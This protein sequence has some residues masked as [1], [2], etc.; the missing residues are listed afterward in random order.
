MIYS[1]RMQ[2][3]DM[4][5][6]R[7]ARP[8]PQPLAFF[9]IALATLSCYILGYSLT[10]IL[11]LTGIVAAILRARGYIRGG[12]I[13]WANLVFFLNGRRLHVYG[14]ERMSAG[15][16]YLVLANHC[17]M[18]DIP[19]LLAVAPEA[20]LVGRDKLMRIPVFS[21]LLKAIRYIPIDTERM[22]QA[23]QAIDEAVR[24]AGQGLSIGMFPEGTR[25][26]TGS[27]QRLKRGFIYVLRASGLDVLPL[28]IRGTFALKP[29]KQLYMDPREKIEV[30]VHPPIPNGELVALTDE[31][32]MDKVR[33]VLEIHTGGAD[34]RQ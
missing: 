28:T 3:T 9:R 29:K 33:S 12:L 26:P 22:R 31:Q 1:Q 19:V 21:Q 10:A 2:D 24:K 4:A 16:A 18:F 13:F 34:E 20:A 32:I 5:N 15:K 8:L 27:V 25:S 14:R 6:V 23:R 17:S 7:P 30:F 11:V